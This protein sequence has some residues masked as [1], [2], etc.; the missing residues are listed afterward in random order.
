LPLA[1]I[2][3]KAKK[4][5]KRAEK[6]REEEERRKAQFEAEAREELIRKKVIE[7][8]QNTY[9]V[10]AGMESETIYSAF[11]RLEE[12]SKIVRVSAT[13]VAYVALS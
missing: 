9:Q 2:D 6:K 10:A 7:R 8:N 13:V 3:W 4:M 12:E 11:E 5:Q 1:Q